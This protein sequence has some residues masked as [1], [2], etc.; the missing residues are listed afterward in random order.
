MESNP[1]WQSQCLPQE[2]G[3]DAAARFVVEAFGVERSIVW[4]SEPGEFRF[5]DGYWCYRVVFNGG[6][7]QVFKMSK[8]T[9][10]AK[11]RAKARREAKSWKT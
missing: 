7:W 8:M 3:R 4:G 10:K 11:E 1:F 5:P 2:T 6:C 9:P